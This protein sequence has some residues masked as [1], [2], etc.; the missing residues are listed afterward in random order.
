[1]KTLLLALFLIASPLPA[2]YSKQ[3]A[4][5]RVLVV[6]NN[7]WSD[8][9]IYSIHYSMKQRIGE[10]TALT[11]KTFH[12]PPRFFRDDSS[13]RLY[14]RPIGSGRAFGDGS[15]TTESLRVRMGGEALLTLSVDDLS[16]SFFSVWNP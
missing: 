1:M 15:H 16:R 10:V 11:K 12:L 9:V 6:E 2:Q 3:K 14:A 4:D 8:V 7:S 13:I 5:T